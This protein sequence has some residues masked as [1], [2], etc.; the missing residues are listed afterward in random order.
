[1]RNSD[2]IV[3]SSAYSKFMKTLFKLSLHN[4]A[5]GNMLIIQFVYKNKSNNKQN[6]NKVWAAKYK[7]VISNKCNIKKAKYVAG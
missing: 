6:S 1:M 5:T 3:T 4:S 2:K 7:N